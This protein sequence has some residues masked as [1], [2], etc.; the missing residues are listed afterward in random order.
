MLKRIILIAFASVTL[1]AAQAASEMEML[2]LEC[3]N[4]CAQREPMPP[5][6]RPGFQSADPYGFP[7]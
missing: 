6:R 3:A 1:P 5:H 7:I 2:R 4:L